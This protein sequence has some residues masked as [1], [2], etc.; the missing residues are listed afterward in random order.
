MNPY[1]ISNS[2]THI[3]SGMPRALQI[4]CSKDSPAGVFPARYFSQRPADDGTFILPLKQSF[5]KDPRL[6]PG[7]RIMLALLVGW[8][9]QGRAL[10]LTKG[11]IA[12]HLGRSI[13]QVF[14]YV[15]DAAREGYLRYSYTKNRLGMITG[16]KI[17][18]KFD[19]LR[20]QAPKHASKGQNLAV[21]HKSEINKNHINIY[22][23]DDHLE[24]KLE[25]LR[26]LIKPE[27]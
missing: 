3:V 24:E 18:L 25:R 19:V 2:L 13:R 21:T 12:K 27:H 1:S 17:W 15:Q 14:R 9:G 23:K 22:N 20:A 7:T 10:E 8:A 26:K 11:T 5:I 4:E 6:M 16:L